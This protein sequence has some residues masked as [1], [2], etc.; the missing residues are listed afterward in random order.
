MRLA[1][2]RES[3]FNELPC[4]H[5]DQ[6]SLGTPHVA[7]CRMLLLSSLQSPLLACYILI[8]VYV[9]VSHPSLHCGGD[10]GDFVLSA[11]V[12][13]WSKVQANHYGISMDV[14]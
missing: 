12:S 3:V 14:C 4:A 6:I 7:K 11:V 9:T 5:C 8:C 10:G 1:T 2:A 13:V